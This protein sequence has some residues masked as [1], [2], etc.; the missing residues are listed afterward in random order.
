[1]SLNFI[2]WLKHYEKE[3]IYQELRDLM[4]PN[5][6][7]DKVIEEVRYNKFDDGILYLTVKV[8]M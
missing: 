7:D 8:N 5:N 1:M 2:R 4:L 3:T 6:C